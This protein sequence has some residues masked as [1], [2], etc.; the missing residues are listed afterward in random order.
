MVFFRCLPV[1][2]ASHLFQTY[3]LLSVSWGCEFCLGS[4]PAMRLFDGALRGWGRCLLGWPRGSPNAAVYVEVGW[5][6]AQS[7]YG[8]L[9]SLPMGDHSP[10]PEL[11]FRVMSVSPN[12]MIQITTPTRFGVGP[13]H[14]DLR[15]QQVN[16]GAHPV[17]YGRSSLPILMP[18][19]GASLRGHDPF[20]GG[21]A[22]R[23]LGTLQLSFALMWLLLGRPV[24]APSLFES[25]CVPCTTS[26]CVVGVAAVSPAGWL[27]Q[28][29]LWT[30][31]STD[32][33]AQLWR[34]ISSC[35]VAPMSCAGLWGG[36]CSAS[37]ALHLEH[38]PS[39]P[40]GVVKVCVSLSAHEIRN[41]KFNM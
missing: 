26:L 2:F 11:V 6:D 10:L 37:G 27:P 33:L 9:S 12:S 4:A 25:L 40:H 35:S 8:R 29:L 3:V 16:C 21:R 1:Q 41:A 20:P 28:H 17:V 19:S 23:H 18:V 34:C 15:S 39:D 7:L 38:V 32:F 5:P 24:N 14:V 30:V 22:A 36:F 31:L 13:H